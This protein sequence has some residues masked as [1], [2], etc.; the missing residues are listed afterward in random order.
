MTSELLVTADFVSQIERF[1]LEAHS[2]LQRSR[3]ELLDEKEWDALCSMGYRLR[4]DIPLQQ[5]E[6]REVLERSAEGGVLPPEVEALWQEMQQRLATAH[7]Y[8]CSAEAGWDDAVRLVDTRLP[9]PAPNL[10]SMTTGAEVQ[11]RVVPGA[12]LGSC[13]AQG[14]PL[15]VSSNPL[16]A[17]RYMHLPGLAQTVLKNSRKQTLFSGLRH[18]F[19]EAEGLNGGFLWRLANVD[20]QLLVGEFVFGEGGPEP[21]FRNLA[22]HIGARSEAIK[23]SPIRA[24]VEARPMKT[25]ASRR[26]ALESAAAALVA[27]RGRLRRALDGN[28]VNVRL[29]AVSLLSGDDYPHWS[30]QQRE[31][32]ALDR[33]GAVVMRVLDPDAHGALRTVRVNAVVRQFV[34]SADEEELLPWAREVGDEAVARLVGSPRTP[35]I[36]GDIKASLDAKSA[37]L[38]TL[39]DQFVAMDQERA[40]IVQLRGANH[41]EAQQLQ[42]KILELQERRERVEKA[43]HA[44]SD[45]GKQLKTM[46]VDEG[47]LPRGYEGHRKAAARLALAGR[48]MGEMPVLICRSGLDLTRQLDPEI[49]FLATIVDNLHGHL[50]LVEEQKGTWEEARSA[51]WPQ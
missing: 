24:A 27:D 36:G 2:L 49:K 5:V 16:S 14:Y 50:P 26:M 41:P 17:D 3:I 15:N 40:R 45:L 37:R 22:G 42:I 20:L 35:D 34:L 23:M 51:F 43:A 25:A 6:L 31:Y 13:F 47:G 21:V 28:I 4:V 38:A 30:A 33:E 18:G 10:V 32:D 19:V 44:L 46:W 39:S 12:A 7:R 29:F 9:I 48:L 1:V 8:L 11:S